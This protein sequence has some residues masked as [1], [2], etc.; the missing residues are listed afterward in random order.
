[1]SKNSHLSPQPLYKRAEVEMTNRIATGTWSP[2]EVLPNEFVLAEEFGVS[3]GTI[4]KAL[5]AMEKRG[6]LVRSPGRGTIVSKTTQEE[7]LYSFFRLRNEKGDLVIPHPVKETVKVRASTKRERKY[8]GE[9]CKKVMQLSRVRAN[10]QRPF[11]L[12]EMS[13]DA[14]VCSGLPDDLPLPP[15][16]Y[17]YLHER[18]GIAVMHVDESISATVADE[19]AANTL[20]LEVGTPLLRVVRVAYDLADRAVELR[21]SLYRT[22]FATYQIKLSRSEG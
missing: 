22:D 9:D 20:A 21:E 10:E 2:G 7:A 18:F 12:E 16:L 8:L 5:V 14:S 19:K 11:A 6:L 17:P 4:R 1:M 15:S 3:Q 13:F